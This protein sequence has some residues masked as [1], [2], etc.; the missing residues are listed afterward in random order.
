MLQ[1]ATKAALSELSIQYWPSQIEKVTQ[2]YGTLL[3]RHGVMLVGPAG[4]GKTNTR[5]ILKRALQVLPTVAAKFEQKAGE[6][7][8]ETASLKTALAFF[9]SRVCNVR[10]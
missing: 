1:K 6:D 5:R 9:V 7:E 3:V 8:V 2:L 10:S 4:G